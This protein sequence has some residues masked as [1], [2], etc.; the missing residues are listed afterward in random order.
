MLPSFS[1][2]TVLIDVASSVPAN[3][4]THGHI[5]PFIVAQ[6][7]PTIMPVLIRFM[8]YSNKLVIYYP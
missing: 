3:S 7:M 6:C 1:H 2:S 8:N 4:K 5:N